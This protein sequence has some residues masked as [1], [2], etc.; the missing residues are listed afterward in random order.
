MKQRMCSLDDLIS[1][2]WSMVTDL[3]DLY[4]AFGQTEGGRYLAVEFDLE[5]RQHHI[6]IDPELKDRL[7]KL[8]QARGIS[9]ESLANLWLQERALAAEG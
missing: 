7:R 5:T 8:A 2:L 9:L 1:D 4:A 6:A 3:E